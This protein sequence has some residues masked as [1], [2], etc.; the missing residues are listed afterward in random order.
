M[1]KTAIRNWQKC[2]SALE[3]GSDTVGHTWFHPHLA[4]TYPPGQRYWKGNFW[5]ATSDYLMKLAPLVEPKYKSRGDYENRYEA[6]AWIGKSAVK[7]K[8]LSIK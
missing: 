4:S 6:E 3:T 8:Y 5:W 7:P 2:V 1:E